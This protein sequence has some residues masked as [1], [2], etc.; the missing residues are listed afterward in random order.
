MLLPQQKYI[1]SKE[2]DANGGTRKPV[3]SQVSC[4]GR[5]ALLRLLCGVEADLSDAA[6][7]LQCHA[8]G[9]GRGLRGSGQ[10]QCCQLT[11]ITIKLC[12]L[13]IFRPQR[14]NAVV[15]ATSAS[16]PGDR[17]GLCINTLMTIRG[18]KMANS[19]FQLPDELVLTTLAQAFP[20]RD[21]QIRALGTLLHVRKHPPGAGAS[22]N[23]LLCR[24]PN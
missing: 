15:D 11:L 18:L 4:A 12:Q 19:L 16:S 2:V 3:S 24:L 1:I 5:P 21:P 23:P 8:D 10:W 6:P 7:L 22:S 13:R 17:T 14:Q 9:C 20:C